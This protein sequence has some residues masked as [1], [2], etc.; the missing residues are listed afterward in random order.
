MIQVPVI[1]GGDFNTV[2]EKEEKVG[3]TIDYN[4]MMMFADFINCDGLVD[5]PMNGS[6]FTWFR[7]GSN[8]STSKLDRFLVSTGICS[9]FPNASQSALNRSLSNHCPVLLKEVQSVAIKRPF[10]WFTH[11]ADDLDF[12]RMVKKE[13]CNIKRKGVGEKLRLVKAAIKNWVVEVRSKDVNSTEV[14]ENKIAMLE[15]KIVADGAAHC[16]VSTRNS[17]IQALKA[18]LWQKGKC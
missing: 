15:E 11:W 10:K 9:W 2:K 8:V 7:S 5:L 16:D 12:D 6:S 3:V 18:Q 17:K 13:F 14:L 4:L 1:L